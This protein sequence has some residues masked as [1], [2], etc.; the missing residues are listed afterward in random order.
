MELGMA[1][2]PYAQATYEEAL[3][4]RESTEPLWQRPKCAF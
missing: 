4:R 3:W 2:Y 1:Q